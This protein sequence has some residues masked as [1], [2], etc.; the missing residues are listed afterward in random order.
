MMRAVLDAGLA[1]E[2]WCRAHATRLRRAAGAARRV[3]G[4]ALRRD[5][6]RPGRD[7]RRGRR[8]SSRAR[9]RRCCGSASAPSATSARRRLPHDRLPAGAGRA[10]GA[11]AAAG[12]SYIPTAT[13]AAISRDAAASGPTC[14]RGRVRRINMSQLGDALTDPAL[15]PPV[16]ALVVWDSNPAPDRARPDAGARRA[17]PRGPLHRRARAVHDRHRR[18]TPTSCCRRR[19]SSSTST[20]IFSWGHHYVTL[21]EPAIAPRRRGEAEHRDLPAARRAARARRSVLRGDRRGARSTR[22]SPARP[23]ASARR[24]ARARL[25]QG[26]PRPGPDARTPRAASATPRTADS[27]ARRRGLD[28]LPLRP[29]GRG[30]RRGARRALPA[31]ADHAEDPPL[32]ELDVRQPGAPARRP[33]ASPFV[34]VHPDDAAARGLADG[35]LVRVFNDRGAFSCRARVS[36]DARPGVLVAPMGWWNARLR[37]RASARRPRRR[38]G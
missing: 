17:A 2:E 26:R 19:P 38:S 24:P 10:R 35:A 16:A 5:V 25:G 20:L 34:V 21:N 4:R 6:R 32:P 28:P 29:A 8:A 13:A 27:L 31:R 18:A 14:A 7:D 9:S 3:P 36:D 23:G 37:R 1:D 15:D 12:C 33:A 30:G 22:C 11:T